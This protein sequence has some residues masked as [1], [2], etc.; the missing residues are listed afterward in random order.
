MTVIG[1]A[2]AGIEAIELF[3]QEQPDVTLM[4]L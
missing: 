4:D 1:Q 2:K 3:R